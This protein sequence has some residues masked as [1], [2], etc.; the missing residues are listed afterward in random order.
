MF[1]RTWEKIRQLQVALD[2][3]RRQRMAFR[4]L[5]HATDDLLWRL[6]ELNLN[7]V[8]EASPELHRHIEKAV[9]G[10]PIELRDAIPAS[11]SIQELL[12]G[13]FA[14]QERIFRWRHPDFFAEDDF[15][16]ADRT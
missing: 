13:M 9:S 16:F 4:D 6:E 5:V 7:G 2:G 8:R 11:A 3:R 10:L 12:D 1:D 15:D 14:A